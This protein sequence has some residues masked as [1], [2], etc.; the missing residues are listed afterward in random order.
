MDAVAV[1]AF[2]RRWL[3]TL[4]EV[5]LW[6]LAALAVVVLADRLLARRVGAGWRM[7]MY[8]VVFLRLLAVEGW[9][10]PLGL[11]PGAESAAATS[12]MALV[13]ADPVAEAA[14]AGSASLVA[15]PT[16]SWGT[17]VIAVHLL[18]ALVLG[19]RLV[20][21]HWRVAA[22]VREAK[23]VEVGGR[24]AVA[25]LHPTAGPLA[26]GLLRPRVVLPPSVLELPTRQR[27]AVIRHE[28]AH[29][30]HRDPVIQAALAT[31]CALA[32]PV[33]AVWLA[34]SRLRV[35]ME[36]RADEHATR[37]LDRSETKEYGQMLLR[38]ASTG[39]FAPALG[40]GH[41]HLAARLRA[42]GRRRRASV[43]TQAF[44]VGLAATT[45]FVLIAQRADE[46]PPPPQPDTVAA[47]DTPVPQTTECTLDKPVPRP[48]DPG[49]DRA[50]ARFQRG[51]EAFDRGEL[52]TAESELAEAAW[53]AASIKY[54]YRAAASAAR[55]VEVT[56]AQGNYEDA[57]AWARHT[58]AAFKRLAPNRIEIRFLRAAADV[59]VMT[60]DA[61]AAA[62]YR[63]TAHQLESLCP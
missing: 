38:I 43:A 7:A 42:L 2:G 34:A 20:A 37:P 10:S 63:A 53:L 27:D 3:E 41:G 15:A 39:A 57:S 50:D 32:W 46:E 36:L 56:A 5:N 1:E 33:L 51:I 45:S 54:D 11:L 14:V 60:G 58:E 21:G 49:S 22:V 47:E 8:S 62:D 30:R 44:A 29:L 28:R 23:P 52:E 59:A 40:L 55:L 9:A 4:G 18:G 19:W 35:L 25:L 17:L 12:S 16:W 48:D 13:A 24:G 61:N 26:V 6:M 31:A